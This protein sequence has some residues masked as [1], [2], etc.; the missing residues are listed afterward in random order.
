V[1]RPRRELTPELERALKLRL[2]MRRRGPEF[3]RVDQW[4]HARIE[5]SGWRRPRSLD[6]KIRQQRK[7]YPPKV[8]SGYRKPALARGLHPSGFVEAL[9]YRPEDLDPLDPK[10]YAVRIASGVGLRKRLE[11]IKKAAEKGFYILNP[12]KKALEELK[13]A[14]QRQAEAQQTAQQQAAAPQEASQQQAQGAAQVEEKDKS[15][16]Q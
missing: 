4:R 15:A 13:R 6:N 11:I 1:S 9:V 3:V 14:E 7:G 8:K 12:G 16:G 2:E 10:T 5:D